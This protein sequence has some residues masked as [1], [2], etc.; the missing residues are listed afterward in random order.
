VNLHENQPQLSQWTSKISKAHDFVLLWTKG[1][2]GNVHG[3]IGMDTHK[4][5]EFFNSQVLTSLSLS[6]SLSCS[7]SFFL[8][9]LIGKT[10][11]PKPGAAD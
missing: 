10:C 7:S 9:V 11:T 3:D 5:S 2:H 8:V 1:C 4:L 6:L